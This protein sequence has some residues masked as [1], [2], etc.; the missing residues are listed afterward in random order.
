MDT[1]FDLLWD[2]QLFLRFAA[3]YSSTEIIGPARFKLA[4]A[5]LGSQSMMLHTLRS[6]IPTFRL[7]R[8][9]LDHP[10]AARMRLVLMGPRLSL[11]RSWCWRRCSISISG[12]PCSWHCTSDWGTL[13]ETALKKSGTWKSKTHKT[14]K[15]RIL[16]HVL[17]AQ[18]R[19]R[20]WSV[21]AY[22]H[23]HAQTARI[24]RNT[25]II[26]HKWGSDKCV[27]PH[28]HACTHLYGA[29]SCYGMN[30]C[31]CTSLHTKLHECGA[32]ERVNLPLNHALCHAS[33]ACLVCSH[34]SSNEITVDG[35]SSISK[36]L[37]ALTGLQAIN[38]R[39]LSLCNPMQPCLD[40]RQ[41]DSPKQTQAYATIKDMHQ[42]TNPVQAWGSFTS[43]SCFLTLVFRWHEPYEGRAG[44]PANLRFLV[45][46]PAH[47]E[48][49]REPEK[50]TS[51]SPRSAS[52][53]WH[54]VAAIVNC[55]RRGS[56]PSPRRWLRW[57][58]YCQS[59][60]GAPLTASMQSYLCP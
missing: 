13:L 45:S 27:S 3:L 49:L 38:I 16:Y 48:R 41:T 23:T 20:E 56:H 40:Q 47:R 24:S 39:C 52:P 54:R 31:H 8:V 30:S 4:V 28:T 37:T 5:L 15:S 44:P 58:H 26:K 60:L 59:I 11:L 9:R 6:G 18:I 33:P 10:M 21:H 17:V 46:S 32:R 43:E 7:I 1:H 25:H 55:L 14:R 35:A 34:D 29:T 57:R 2:L 42:Y 19:V 36:T 50:N 12:A 22:Y 53:S 51:D